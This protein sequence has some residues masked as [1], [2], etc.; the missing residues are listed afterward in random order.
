MNKAEKERLAK[1]GKKLN[2]KAYIKNEIMDALNVSYGF[3]WGDANL[4]K[5][6]NYEDSLIICQYS[7]DL[8]VS[9]GFIYLPVCD[10][11][12]DG[13]A[14]YQDALDVCRKSIQLIDKFEV[15]K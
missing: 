6:A 5:K 1:V 14:N 4:D 13:K 15:E 10:V 2:V 12:G 8:P 9:G 3:L 7:I 11:T